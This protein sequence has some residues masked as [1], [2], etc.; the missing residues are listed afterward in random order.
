MTKDDKYI[1]LSSHILYPDL[2][3]HAYIWAIDTVY[4]ISFYWDHQHKKAFKNKKNPIKQYMCLRLNIYNLAQART[5]SFLLCH[6]EANVQSGK[7][8]YYLYS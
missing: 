7:Y 6:A 1:P 2:S 8:R 4:S 3:I 5:I